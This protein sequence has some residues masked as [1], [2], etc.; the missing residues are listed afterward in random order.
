MK[1]LSSVSSKPCSGIVCHHFGQGS[2]VLWSLVSALQSAEMHSQKR[3]TSE[4]ADSLHVWLNLQRKKLLQLICVANPFS[5]KIK[6]TDLSKY[7]VLLVKTVQ[8][9]A[10]RDVKLGGVE[11]LPSGCHAERALPFVPQ[12]GPQL[13][14][15]ESCLLAIQDAARQK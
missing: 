10:R 14:V 3:R 15:K 13:C 11:V 9:C 4:Y 8:L 1:H 12:V 2:N 7:C 5:L 6:G